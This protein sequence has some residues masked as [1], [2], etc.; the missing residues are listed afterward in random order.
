[1]NWLPTLHA[2]WQE[3][4][5][6]TTRTLLSVTG[7]AVGLASLILMLSITRGVEKSWLEY[8][9]DEGG[10]MK[11]V[12]LAI[13]PVVNGES[14]SDLYRPFVMGD[15]DTVLGLTEWVRVASPELECYAPVHYGKRKSHFRIFAGGSSLSQL[16]GHG[17]SIGRSLLVSDVKDSKRV[18]VVGSEVV[19]QLLGPENPIGIGVQIGED[20][21][22]VVGVLDSKVVKK[23]APSRMQERNA[24]IYIPI[25]AYASY[26]SS[27]DAWEIG[28]ISFQLNPAVDIATAKSGIREVLD[29]V[30]RVP[31]GVDIRI[32][33]ENFNNYRKSIRTM[34]TGFTLIAGVALF[35]GGIGVLN[36]MIA[37]IAQRVGEIGIR[38]ALGAANVDIFRQFL[39]EAGLVS[40][41]GAV[42]GLVL[43][44]LII[45]A[46]RLI[47]SLNPIIEPQVLVLAAGFAML[48]GLSFGIYPALR[49]ARLDPIEALHYQ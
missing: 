15:V 9:E 48:I 20:R 4:Q 28:N 7:I 30:R 32:N 39:I 21:Y 6:N 46:V 19:V 26:R 10:L 8:F 38:K 11:G 1:V 40:G 31:G 13:T 5:S 47:T 3:L 42:S 2:G 41:V 49:A 12:I 18:C 45:Q 23:V 33:I 25:T 36:I 34:Q 29:R 17:L 44:V 16:K 37:T 22:T 14:R 24:E 35:V 43:A 27:V